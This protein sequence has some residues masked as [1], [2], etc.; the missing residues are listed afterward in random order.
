MFN[1]GN[2]SSGDDWTVGFFTSIT[3]MKNV[4]V[5][6]GSDY[7]LAS[8][9]CTQDYMMGASCGYPT[10]V[11][12]SYVVMGNRTFNADDTGNLITFPGCYITIY[13]LG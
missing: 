10:E 2:S 8:I 11:T 12:S 5:T 13:E 6:R 9:G 7:K 3:F 1:I 4:L